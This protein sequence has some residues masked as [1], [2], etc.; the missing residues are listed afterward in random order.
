MWGGWYHSEALMT[1]LKKMREIA[2]SSVNKNSEGFPRAEV[3]VFMDE[4]A[5]TNLPRGHHLNGAPAGTRCNMSCTGIPYDLCMVEDAPDIVNK[6]RAAIF[7]AAVPSE[8]GR[9]AL[10]LFRSKGIYCLEISEE[11]THYPPEELREL[12]VGAGVHCYNPDREIIYAGGGFIGIH[13]VCDGEKIL[14]LPR[15]FNIRMV[16]GEN[17]YETDGKTIKIKMKKYET[18]LFEL[19]GI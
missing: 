16:L 1:E 14:E 10:E 13:S 7:T 8:S 9:K 4:E 12:L 2:E 3:A 11:K 18:A 5:L 15:R 17:T 19:E 6:Y